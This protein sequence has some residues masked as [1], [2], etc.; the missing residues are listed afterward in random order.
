[1]FAH[2]AMSHPHLRWKLGIADIT[3]PGDR[4]VESF[5]GPSVD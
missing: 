5:T 4:N 2:G 3:F 1:M